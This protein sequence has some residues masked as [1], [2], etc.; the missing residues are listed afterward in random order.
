MSLNI[1]VGGTWKETDEVYVKVS[2]TWQRLDEVYVNVSGVWKP[3]FYDAGSSVITSGS[4]TFTVPAGVYS[5]TVDV[6][7]GG[8]AGGWSNDGNSS[9]SGGSG[10]AGGRITGTISVVPF[11]TI[12]YS[13]GAGAAAYTSWTGF[14]AYQPSGSASTITVSG[15]VH[16]ANGGGGGQNGQQYNAATAG[17]SA[18]TTSNN[19]GGFT[20]T[21]GTAGTGGILGPGDYGSANG[22]VGASSA[23]GS[24]GSAGNTS[25]GDTFTGGS[26]GGNASGYGA[27]GGSAGYR[28]RSAPG[29]WQGGDGSGGRISFSW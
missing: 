3:M 27:G 12:A 11:Q 26:A 24:G 9:Y 28:D 17:G 7:G 19:G 14:G 22:V 6:L 18:G 2:D 16:S 21:N 29:S 1:A 5:L 15:T 13:V 8:G 23:Y 20:Y 10:A 4:G 25:G